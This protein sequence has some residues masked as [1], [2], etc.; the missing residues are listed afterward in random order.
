MRT[1][2]GASGYDRLIAIGEQTWTDYEVTVPFTVNAIGPGAGSYLSN[3]AMIG[4]ALRWQGHEQ[5]RTKQ[6]D[7]DF[8]TVGAYAWYRFYDDPKI[9]LWGDGY[10][11]RDW[12]AMPLTIGG[13]Y[14]MHATVETV[15][16]TTSTYTLTIYPASGAP[17]D[18]WTVT[19]TGAGPNAGSFALIAHQVDA[20]FGDVVIEPL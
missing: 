1:A 7:E 12:A 19:Y 4:V 16:S 17:V 20:T 6:P 18:G 3:E 11:R 9:E 13:E 8:R 5:S 10:V 2:P 14:I 15:T